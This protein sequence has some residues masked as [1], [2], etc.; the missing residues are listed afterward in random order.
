MSGKR[1]NGICFF[2]GYAED[3]PRSGVI[4]RGAE[5]LGVPVRSC[6]A[7]Q[8]KKMIG[9]YAALLVRYLSMK[10]DFSIV[11][12]PEFRHKDVPLAWILGKL[13]G[14]PVVFDPLVSRYETKIQDRKDAAE[15]SF[16]A[17][18]NRRIDEV[19]MRLPR[20]VLAD[21]LAH[22]SYFENEFKARNVAV[23]P[24]GFDE[25]VFHPPAG[26]EIPAAAP[27]AALEPA[28]PKTPSAAQNTVLFFGSYVPLHGVE[29][30]VKAAALLEGHAGIRFKLIG[31]GQTF[32]RARGLAFE[33]GRAAVEFHPRVPQDELPRHIAGAQI[34]LGI[35]GDSDKAFRV[36]PNKV[37]QCLAMRKPVITAD[38][39]AMREIFTDGV[40]CCMVPAGDPR[41][42]AEK[43]RFLVEHPGDA[44]RIAEAGF[45]LV[46][47]RFT[48]GKIGELFIH[49]CVE[50]LAAGPFRT[51]ERR[52]GDERGR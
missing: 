21:T 44:G 17:W 46:R 9:R 25:S 32:A 30:I 4:R 39:G 43:I 40:H 15:R 12:V 52:T 31:D 50:A 42:L 3:Y 38:T 11:F 22:A 36:I 1:V 51:Q 37:Y 33:G 23:L 27:N 29:T 47:E 19:S 7:S 28:A 20:L 24:V 8:K 26:P 14:K 13:T 2:G 34:C 18:Y 10:K 35:F 5:A 49:Y 48:S 45:R 41:A 16:Q 6:R